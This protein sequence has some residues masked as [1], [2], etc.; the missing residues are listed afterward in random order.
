M[1]S[2]QIRVNEKMALGK[3]LVA[4][5]Q[6]IP[7]IVTFEAQKEKPAPKSEL[8]NGL[9]SAFAEVRLMLDGKKKEKSLDEFLEEMRKEAKNELQ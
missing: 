6:S 4:Y 8:Y 2:Y 5:L 7:Q 3:S 9:N 1:A